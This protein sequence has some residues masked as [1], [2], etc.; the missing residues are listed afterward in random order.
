MHIRLIS[1]NSRLYDCCI[2]A[3]IYGFAQCSLAAWPTSDG[4]KTIW[5][6]Q[7]NIIFSIS[8]EFP[9]SIVFFIYKILSK[10]VLTGTKYFFQNAFPKLR[11]LADN[12]F[13]YPAC[14]A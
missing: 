6:V 11:L 4:E 13:Q 9:R 14:A 8:K 2:I 12:T 1:L 7:N 3:C 10:S 5:K